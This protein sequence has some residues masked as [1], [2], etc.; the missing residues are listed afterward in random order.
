MHHIEQALPATSSYTNLMLRRGA[1]HCSGPPISEM[2]YTVSSGMLNSVAVVGFDLT[3]KFFHK[4]VVD[5]M[6]ACRRHIRYLT[7][8][9]DLRLSTPTTQVVGVL[10]LS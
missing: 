6:P 2:T 3:M 9:L 7:G 10:E 5:Q 4:L 1:H 8:L